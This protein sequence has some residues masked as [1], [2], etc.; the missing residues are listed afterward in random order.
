MYIEPN[1]TLQLFRGLKLDGDYANT[2]WFSNITA[3]NSFF[4][5]LRPIGLANYSYQRKDIGVIKVQLPISQA[6]NLT[7]MRFI[8]SNFENKWF[9]AFIDKV[10]YVNN[11]TCY[12]YYAL[13]LIQTYMFDWDL[14]EC[15]IERQHSL[16]DS[17]GDNLEI[18]GLEI[19][20]AICDGEASKFTFPTDYTTA[21]FGWSAIIW[22]AP[23]PTGTLIGTGETGMICGVETGLEGYV[24]DLNTQSG[25]DNFI[26]DINS[27]GQYA[28]SVANIVMFPSEWVYMTESTIAKNQGDANLSKPTSLN[29][30]TPTNKKLL[31]YPYCWFNWY[32]DQGDSVDLRYELFNST[33][34]P[35]KCPYYIYALTSSTPEITIYPMNYDGQSENLNCSL[36]VSGFPIIGYANDAYKA[37]I[38]MNYD[39]NQL[40]KNIA[41]QQLNL[42]FDQANL[43]LDKS[44]FN[45]AMGLAGAGLRGAGAG[46]TGNVIGAA[47]GITDI[48]GSVANYMYSGKQTLLNVQNAMLDQY[49]TVQG[50]NIK[51]SVARRLPN[52][53]HNGSSSMA[54]GS[55][56]KGF[57]FQKMSIRRQFAEKVDKFFTMFGY[58]QNKV[59][60]PNIHARQQFTY[61]KT[62]GCS[63]SGSIPQ[64]DKTAINQIFD[65]G[66]RFWTDYQNFENYN[67]SN[68]IV[69]P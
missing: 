2:M 23:L 68:P 22:T 8:N 11:E 51:E 27:L 41:N 35:N 53:P 43:N 49:K 42:A 37:W 61:I 47:G 6:Y 45:S 4:T 50:A 14:H 21:G 34:Y 18:E 60:T 9:Y 32:T 40:T 30:Y 25:R 46:A 58:A 13:D 7:Y 12:I 57:Y 17:A 10:E 1:T 66:I 38:A 39:S 55:H 67:V 20:D 5:G 28:D 15:V 48:V 54:V 3:Q 29:G 62:A 69:T 24:Y 16:T 65:R 26:N 63:I 64:D 56:K 52:S 33:T 36:T 31:T 19:G 44:M 59:A